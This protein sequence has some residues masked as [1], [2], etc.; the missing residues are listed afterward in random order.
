MKNVLFALLLL[1]IPAVTMAQQPEQ[2]YHPPALFSEKVDIATAKVDVPE[3]TKPFQGK[4][5]GVSCPSGVA[6]TFV[7][8]GEYTQLLNLAAGIGAVQNNIG[9][10]AT[11]NKEGD[12]AVSFTYANTNQQYLNFKLTSKDGK[13]V[14]N[15]AI[16]DMHGISLATVPVTFVKDTY[17]GDIVK[18]IQSTEGSCTAP[19]PPPA[20]K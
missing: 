10:I 13:L 14:G 16:Q 3:Y 4:W 1:A 20:T 17:K 15:M 9:A 7:I 19:A 18:F 8:N 11:F 12:N 2:S 5:Q 6:V